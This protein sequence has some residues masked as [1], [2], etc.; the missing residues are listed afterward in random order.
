MKKICIVTGTRA[1]WGLFYPLAKRIKEDSELE[2]KIIATGMHLSEKY[3]L[4]YKEIERDGFR[5]DRKE[6]ILSEEDTE[7]GAA[8]STGL[9]VIKITEA[10]RAIEPDLV[11]LLGDRFETFSAAIS[12]FLLKIPIAHI[13]GGELTE[14]A[15]DDAFRHS[16]TKMAVL[17]FTS[18]D[19]Y[20]K[21]VI[22]MGEDPS[23][24]FNV[25]ALGLCGIKDTK[26]LG[27]EDLEKELGFK[28]G[29][30]NFLVTFHPVTLESSEASKKQM[31]NLLK[32]L[33]Q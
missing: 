25:G 11:V 3:G 7:E 2:L 16:I 13:H 22:Q 27:K 23:R 5:I 19:I 21:R 4:T 6:E 14:G 18:T 28:F 20:R 33:D 8:K 15:L 31:E 1:E 24:V 17:H 26:V 10:F 12:A 30:K 32:A 29:K 9:A